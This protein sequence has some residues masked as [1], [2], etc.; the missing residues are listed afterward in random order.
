MDIEDPAQLRAYLRERGWDTAEV[1]Q[2]RINVLCGGVSNRT[3]LVDFPGGR[4]LVLKQALAKLRVKTDWFCAPERI[5]REAAGLR[6]LATLA[7][8]S[9]IT[10]FVFEDIN[11]HMLAME[12]VP[13]PH[14]NWKSM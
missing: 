5:H 13:Q 7:P 14:E 12:A 9:A 4:S 3:V 1:S 6:W 10:P 2:A 8:Q 11:H